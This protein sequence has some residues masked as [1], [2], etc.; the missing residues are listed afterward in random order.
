M[1]QKFNV[2]YDILVEYIDIL[3]SD[4]LLDNFLTQMVIQQTKAGNILDLVL[5]NSADI[6]QDVQ[7]LMLMYTLIVAN[8][9]RKSFIILRKSFIIL[10]KL[11]GSSL[12]HSLKLFLGI[13]RFYLRYT[14]SSLIQ[15]L[16]NVF[17]SAQRVNIIALHGF[18]MKYCSLYGRRE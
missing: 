6:I 18:Q 15:Q 16:T 7:H 3:I 10:R 4:I 14:R 2:K 9:L 1:E 17:Q 11:I 13:V 8:T 5:S 12:I